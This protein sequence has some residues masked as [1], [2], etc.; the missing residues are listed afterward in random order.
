MDMLVGNIN[1]KFFVS[2]EE[3]FSSTIRATT[4]VDASLTWIPY[5]VED[6]KFITGAK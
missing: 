4:T 5:K 2:I 6:Y 1:A 3:G